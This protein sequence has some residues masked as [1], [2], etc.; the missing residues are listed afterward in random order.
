MQDEGA[1]AATPFQ[2]EKMVK[3]GRQV[4]YAPDEVV[5]KE[6]GSRLFTTDGH[7]IREW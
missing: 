7:E 5:F 4:I 2:I 3:A 1:L 6:A